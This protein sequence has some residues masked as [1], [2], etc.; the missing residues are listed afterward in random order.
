M[1]TQ[2]G[3]EVA[4]A[5]TKT[6]TTQLVALALLMT[7]LADDGPATDGMVDG[8]RRLPNVLQQILA[9][10]TAYVDAGGWLGGF[11]NLF[12]IAKGS[13][14]PVALETAL[15]FKEVAYLHAEGVPAGELKHGAFALLSPNTPVLAFVDDDDNRRRMITAIRE[16]KARG[17]PLAVVGNS[18]DPDVAETAD[19]V[20]RTP[21][22]RPE[23]TPVVNTVVGQL[24]S[25]HAALVR[26]CPVDRPRNLAKSV[27]VL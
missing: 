26:G 3:P 18:S 27:T 25:Y 5:A 11:E 8:L 12:V 7:K 24:L 6:F 9:E 19:I 2:A 22:V 16:I 20:I 1:Y 15:K 23:L 10:K 21:K 17:G 14:Y 4:V 13:N